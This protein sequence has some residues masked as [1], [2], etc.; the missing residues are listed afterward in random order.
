MT[1]IQVN[2]SSITEDYKARTERLIAKI[3]SFP[4]TRNLYLFIPEVVSPC[5]EK[6]GAWK[7]EFDAKIPGHARFQP[8]QRTIQLNPTCDETSNLASLIF[9]MINIMNLPQFDHLEILLK[10]GKIGKEDYAKEI[11]RLEFNTGLLHHRV[12]SEAI[13][14]MNWP[15]SIDHYAN[16]ENLSFEDFWKTWQFTAHAEDYRIY[17]ET[18]NQKKSQSAPLI[19]SEPVLADSRFEITDIEDDA[20]SETVLIEKNDETISRFEIIDIEDDSEIISQ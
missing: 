7:I 14:Q 11:L 8:F 20:S 15:S 12:A 19:V 16:F 9:E 17:W 6:S 2:S 13:R 4:K 18:I 1:V 3:Q 5:Y 10:K